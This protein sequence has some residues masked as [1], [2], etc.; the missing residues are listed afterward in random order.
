MLAGNETSGEGDGDAGAAGR[1]GVA[2]GLGIG[3]G[4]RRQRA[5]ALRAA[6]TGRGR[7]Q[8]RAAQVPRGRPA[9]P[10]PV[11]GSALAAAHSGAAREPARAVAG[12]RAATRAATAAAPARPAPSRRQPAPPG[13]P[14][15]TTSVTNI[16]PGQR[17]S[18]RATFMAFSP[19][20]FRWDTR[21]GARAVV[22]RT[23]RGR[24]AIGHFGAWNAGETPAHGTPATAAV[25]THGSANG[26]RGSTSTLDR[27]ASTPSSAARPFVAGLLEL[28]GELGAAG[29]ARRARP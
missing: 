11:T 18:P 4:R 25:R 15:A 29:L 28:L 8:G 24:C 20:A 1:E 14:K 23:E 22:N 7:R 26:S 17:P 3:T 16:R 5:A 12:V 2:R 27:R 21:S 13:A 19:S 9:A 6:A 10:A